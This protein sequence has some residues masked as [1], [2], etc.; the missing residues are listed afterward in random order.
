MADCIFCK[1]AAEEIPAAKV[2]EDNDIL[3]FLDIAPQNKGHLL[4]IPKDHIPYMTDMPDDSLG[5][6]FVKA[7][8]IMS[9]LKDRIGAEFVVV[10]VVGTD[11]A[12]FHVHLIPIQGKAE[13]GPYAEGE[14]N[15]WA[16]KLKIESL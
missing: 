12:H 8:K 16:E 3:G 1:I 11:V 6:M 7:K 14:M 10:K 5:E 15:A 13:E 9:I 2:Y 4:L